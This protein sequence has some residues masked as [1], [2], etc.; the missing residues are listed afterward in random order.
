MIFKYLCTISSFR[1]HAHGRSL[2]TLRPYQQECIDKCLDSL[3][4]GIW[5][6]AVSLPV[7]SGKTVVFSNLIQRIPAPTSMATKTLVLAHRE[8]LLVQAARQIQRASP[9]LVVEID[10]GTRMANPAADVVVASV[11]TLGRQDSPRLLRHDPQRYKCIVIDEAH[12]A[13]ASTYGRILDHFASN[14]KIFIWGC[15][16]TLHR[17]DG[18]GLSDVFDKIVYQ[19]RFIEMIRERWLSHM[20]VITVR[21]ATQLNAV[22]NYAGEFSTGSLSHAVNQRERNLA[23]VQAYQSLAAD[24][25]SVLVFA[26]DVA[27]AK[28]LT[29][30]FNRYHINAHYVLGSTGASERERILFEFREGKIPVVVNC[31]I[32]TEGTDI[33][34]I[35][36]VIMARP[37]RSPVLFQQMLGRGMRLHPGK[38]DCL[39]VDFV[40][41][42]KHDAAQV[43]VPTLLGLDPSLVLD[44]SDNILDEN[45]LRRKNQSERDAGNEI[46]DEREAKFIETVHNFEE[47]LNEQILPKALSSLKALG[48][49][50]HVHLNPLRFFELGKKPATMSDTKFSNQLEVVSSGDTN[51]AAL[52]R[53]AW[54]CLS[55][56]RY[57]LNVGSKMYYVTRKDSLWYGSTRNLRQYVIS[58][59]RK[60]HYTKEQQI[61]LRAETLAMAIK[62]MDSLV[63]SSLSNT[64][65][66]QLFW[67]ANWRCKPPTCKQVSML[68]KLGI[69]VPESV[70]R[71][72][73][74]EN[75]SGVCRPASALKDDS[76]LQF[77]SRQTRLTR[78][79]AA[80]LILRLTHGSSKQWKQFESA[81]ERLQDI[82]QRRESAAAANAIWTG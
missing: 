22:R 58:G 30:T 6:Q 80:N 51:L 5:R 19:K 9:N 21:T 24:R 74:P 18:L 64:M 79:S 57:L 75:Q 17:H 36:C 33:P 13:A 50:A 54:V 60:M 61:G 23:V 52:S 81:K 31:G 15:S 10:Q 46:A 39:I 59:S 40:D 28:A 62:G 48:Y 77:T 42:F 16:A 2:H 71:L 4:N 29:Q 41:S 66:K 45:A 70:K 20:R 12:H 32:L 56:D 37:T 7:G 34:N 65:K 72:A 11:P 55:S 76:N 14:S 73:D 27:H 49:R 78:G 63:G 67:T 43:T 47:S 25:K 35:D 26:V 44:C 3:K 69:R 8:E 53:F 1:L 68:S 82:Q 38:S